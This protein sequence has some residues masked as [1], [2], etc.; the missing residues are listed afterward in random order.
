MYFT[1]GLGSLNFMRTGNYLLSSGYIIKRVTDGYW[2]T[3]TTRSSTNVFLLNAGST[4]AL[5]S[6]GDARGW[7]FAIRC[8]I[9]VE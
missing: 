3:N 7:G 9:R 5:P 2:W 6:H 4:H 8:T 1:A